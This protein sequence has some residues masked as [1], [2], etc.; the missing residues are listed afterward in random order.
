VQEQWPGIS[1]VVTFGGSYAGALSGFL[2]LRLPHLISA[3]FATSSPV[4]AV[5]DF[6]GARSIEGTFSTTALLLQCTCFYCVKYLGRVG[7]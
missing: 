2:R 5:V 3:A 7:F 1:Q 6:V 4:Q